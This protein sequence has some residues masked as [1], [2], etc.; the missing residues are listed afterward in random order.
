MKILELAEKYGLE[1]TKQ[2]NLF[3]AYCPFHR[4]EHRP[5]FTIYKDTDSYYCYT[6][7]RGGDAVDFYARM[8]KIS[9]A[10]AQYKL[11]SDL[12]TLRD[13]INRVAQPAPYNSTLNLQLSSQFRECLY[14]HPDQL[15]EVMK[16]MRQV[17]QRL[18]QDIN[19]EEAVNLVAE[20]TNKLSCISNKQ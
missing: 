6:C 13:K 14:A 9:Y 16:I 18:I 7:S 2:G 20:V 5:N 17:D 1:T 11:Y 3:I 12:Q 19:Q 10:Q 8:E 4:D 15:E